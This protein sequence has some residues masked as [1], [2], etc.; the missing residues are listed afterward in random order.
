MKKRLQGAAPRVLPDRSVLIAATE[1]AATTTPQRKQKDYAFLIT[2][3]TGCRTGAA[4]G[5]RHCDIDL[6]NKT[7]TFANWEKVVTYQKLR[8][9]KRR[10]NQ[11]RRLKTDKDERTIPISTAL[12]ELIKDM[13]LIKGSDEPSGHKDIRQLMTLG[14][15]IIPTNTNKS[16]ELKLM[17]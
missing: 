7:I 13:P 2:R 9:G 6:E 8:G 11:N 12:Y 10:E 3:Y 14:V 1:K 5:L 16:M 17:T 4:N 15:M